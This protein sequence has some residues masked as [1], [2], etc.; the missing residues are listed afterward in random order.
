MPRFREGRAR[1]AD[2]LIIDD[3]ESI[4]QLV[5]VHLEDAGYTVRHAAD[6]VEGLDKAAQAVLDLIIL[7]I[8]MP[9]MDGTH[10][11]KVLRADA[12]MDKISVIALSAMSAPEM[13][14]DMHGLGC[15]AYVSKP[16]NFAVLLSNVDRLI[17]G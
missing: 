17:A 8:N 15:E 5:A 3:D 12:T 1:L 9:V 6:G 13:R 7:D 2:I 16:I 10:V 11:M 4:R 14:D